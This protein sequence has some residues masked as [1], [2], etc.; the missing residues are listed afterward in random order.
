MLGLPY[1]MFDIS[2][3]VNKLQAYKSHD[4]G[5]QWTDFVMT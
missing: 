2:D 1:D 5:H 3:Y 4:H